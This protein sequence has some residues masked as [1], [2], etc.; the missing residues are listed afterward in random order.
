MQSKAFPHYRN[1][2]VKVLPFFRI[3]QCYSQMLLEQGPCAV[4]F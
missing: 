2:Y 4:L 3:S 1:P